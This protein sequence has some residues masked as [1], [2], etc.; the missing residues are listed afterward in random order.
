MSMLKGKLNKE[1]KERKMKGMLSTLIEK[2][3]R[4]F[5]KINKCTLKM[6]DSFSV[7]III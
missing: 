2:K 6:K 5:L 3:K 1:T 7:W 4:F